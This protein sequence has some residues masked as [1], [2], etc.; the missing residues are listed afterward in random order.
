MDRS[1]T[2]VSRLA[3]LLLGSL[4][5]AACGSAAATSP[6]PTVSPTAAAAKHRQVLAKGL[7]T[8]ISATSISVATNNS[9]TETFTLASGATAREGNTRVPLSTVAVGQQVVLFPPTSGD[10]QQVRQIVIRSPLATPS[11]SPSAAA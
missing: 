3:A 2:R 6:T 9:G 11:A 5:L 10:T 7:V 4:A 1:H 8:A